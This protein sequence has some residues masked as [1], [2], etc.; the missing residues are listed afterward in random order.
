MAFTPQAFEPSEQV[1]FARFE[2]RLRYGATVKRGV[3]RREVR[4]DGALLRLDVLLH[5]LVDL[6]EDEHQSAHRPR[7][8]IVNEKQFSLL[9][10]PSAAVAL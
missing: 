9:F 3:Q 5:D 8:E 10:E 1:L 7:Q 6:F 4:H 2:G